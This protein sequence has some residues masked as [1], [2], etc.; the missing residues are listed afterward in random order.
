MILLLNGSLICLLMKRI[1]L[2]QVKQYTKNAVKT[3]VLKLK[4]SYTKKF[5]AFT[6][7]KLLEE[8][9]WSPGTII[10]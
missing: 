4:L 1:S 10:I 8:K 2:K 6:E 9:G 5:I 3:V 7:N